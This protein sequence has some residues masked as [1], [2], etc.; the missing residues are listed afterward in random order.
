MH[1]RSPRDRS[2][3]GFCLGLLAA[4]IGLAAGGQTLGAEQ[5]W[6]GLDATGE[7]R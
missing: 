2:W 4:G 5:Q 7:A 3:A 1:D 6:R